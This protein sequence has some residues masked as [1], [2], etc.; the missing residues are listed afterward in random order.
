MHHVLKRG[1]AIITSFNPCVPNDWGQDLRGGQAA[2]V[3]GRRS[4]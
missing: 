3:T 2:R 4:G 1:L